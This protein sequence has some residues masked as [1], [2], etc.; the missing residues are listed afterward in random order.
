MISAVGHQTDFTIADFVADLRAPTPSAAA[1]LVIRQKSEFV[2]MISGIEERLLQAVRYR[3]ATTGRQVL[4]T[5][6]NRAAAS[7][8]RR[9]GSLW[10]RAR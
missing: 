2:E 9:L 5:S 7:L 8:R 3:L 1:E 4:E 6:V 10:Q